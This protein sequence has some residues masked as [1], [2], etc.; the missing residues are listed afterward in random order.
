MNVPLIHILGG[1]RTARSIARVLG[2]CGAV[3]VGQVCN[4]SLDSARAAVEFIGAGQPV[5]SFD[6]GLST[7]WLMVGLPDGMIEEAIAVLAEG[8]TARPRLA[9][10]LSGSVPSTVLEPLG[11]KVASVHPLKAF[12]DPEQASAS[13][14][15]TWCATEGECPA[16]ADLRPVFEQA[17]ARWVEFKP[18]NKAAWHA[19]TVAAS[20]FLV[21]V[22]ALAREL[23]EL[24]GM[25][26][27]DAARLLSDLQQGTL[28]N[29]AEQPAVRALTGP[30]ER[31]DLSACRRLHAAVHDGLSPTSAALFDHLAQATLALAREKRGDRPDDDE[32]ERLFSP[33]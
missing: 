29:L 32:L 12:S 15:G 27:A 5:E 4:R 31:G 3:R 25:E 8:L 13:F 7:G 11:C 24:A 26:Q 1:G 20:N 19:A 14:A 9:F 21:T 16:L 2:E 17:E 22:N 33:D 10:H 23:A 18:Q 28:G 30:F 6:A